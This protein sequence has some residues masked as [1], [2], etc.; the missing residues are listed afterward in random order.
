MLNVRFQHEFDK[1]QAR[2]DEMAQRQFPFAASKAIN[3]TTTL[4]VAAM[5]QEMQ[6]VFDRPTPW[7]LSSIGRTT[8]TK[9][10]LFADV[11]VKDEGYKTIVPKKALGHQFSGGE[12]AFK[13]FEGA[14]LRIGL[15]AQG[16][17]AVPGAG[18][19]LDA[20]GN[21]SRGQIVQILAYMQAFS[22]QGYRANM[23]DKG[24]RRLARG[25][26]KAF[27]TAYFF[28]RDGPGRGIWA[29]YMFSKGSAIKP[30][31]L[32]VDAPSYQRRINMPQVAQAVVDQEFNREF[33]DAFKY[34]MD[35]A[36]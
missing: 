10:R 14:L 17:V 33:V 31:L 2:I 32:F 1:L 5:K 30:V 20:Y 25:A 4:A 22:E 26:K 35:T 19:Q 15:M 16:E 9:E 7:T 24:K 28:R 36:R 21:I 23:N 18:A 3:A 29:R 11:F 12:R 34:A 27:G 13:K 8:S 6:R